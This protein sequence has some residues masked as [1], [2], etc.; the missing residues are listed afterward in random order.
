MCFLCQVLLV[1]ALSSAVL[2]CRG[3]SRLVS[4][5][6]ILC[7]YLTSWKMLFWLVAKSEKCND[8]AKRNRSRDFGAIHVVYLVVF[9][10]RASVMTPRHELL[11]TKFDRGIRFRLL[12]HR[13]RMKRGLLYTCC[14]DHGYNKLVLAQHLD[15]LA[16]SF[17]M[18][19]LHNGQV[20]CRL[21]RTRL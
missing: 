19:A 21:C 12:R 15:D 17:I 20:R 4:F 2:F 1:V 13:G 8:A 7:P 6:F 14:R 10:I 16:E 11:V 18:S 9:F 5:R 3:E